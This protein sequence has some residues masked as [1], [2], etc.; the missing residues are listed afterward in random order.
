MLPTS[1]IET[2][3]SRVAIVAS[4]AVFVGLLLALPAFYQSF[5][6]AKYLGI[7]YQVLAGHGPLTLFGAI[8]LPHSPFWSTLIAAPSVWFGI[9]A[10]SWSHLLNGLSGVGFVLVI[11]A[12]GWQLRPAIGGLAAVGC[13][14]VPYLHDLARTGRLDVPAATLALLY[15]WIGLRAVR[16]G[17]IGL[18]IAAGAIFALGFL[19][20][21]IALPFAPIPSIIGLLEGR[22]LPR[23]ARV[24]A[25]ILLVA[26]AGVAWWFVVYA[27]Y[28]NEA[29]RLG[30]PAWTLIPLT[31]AAVGLGIVGS[32]AERIAG[33]SRVLA[34]VRADPAD[35]AQPPG[36][37]RAH[38]RELSGAIATLAWFLA[39]TFFFGRQPELKGNGLF[40]PTQ[41]RLYL[42]TWLPQ[43][44][45]VVMF[46]IVG[47]GLAIVAW[48]R[49]S[50]VYHAGLTMLMVSAVCSAPLVL[51]VMAVGEPPRNYLAQIGILLTLGAA[52]WFWFAQA[53]LQ[54]R[55]DRLTRFG[56]LAFGMGIGATAGLSLAVLTPLSVRPGVIGGIALGALAGALEIVRR[57][58][59][60]R[61]GNGQN[62]AIAASIVA[63]F[64]AGTSL[65]AE[66]ALAHPQS[67]SANARATSIITATSWI[68]ANEPA[69]TKV[70]FG[71]L[72]GYE[73]ALLLKADYPMAQ[74]VQNLV[75]SDPKSPDGLGVPGI[76]PIHDFIAV[77]I[78]PRRALEFQIF[79]ASS[80]QKQILTSG[81][82]I[83][84]YTIGTTTSVPSLVPALTPD[85]GFTLLQHWSWR[86]STKPD[87]IPLETYIFAVDPARVG[88]A[89]R[90]MYF[91]P[92]ALDRLLGLLERDPAAARVA[93]ADLVGRVQVSGT[94][95]Q[96]APLLARLK[97]LAGG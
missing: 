39:L 95:A 15:V 67:A 4:V 52:G 9:D 34:R 92:D 8:F 60:A 79:R 72:L 59:R 49:T 12:L 55:R 32:L 62:L 83:Y 57:P 68:R 71:S 18:A 10:A 2:T 85:H 13:L 94:D 96:D 5:D 6:E 63:T 3:S 76:G 78:S 7:G 88:F 46:G 1:R 40:Q 87:A 27:G 11:G 31:I 70:G 74:M 50:G 86:G 47:V 84:V 36:R 41:L 30:T 23:L 44:L 75:V 28:T 37:L 20:K 82:Q 56:P 48:F 80:F 19:V 66:H 93:A 73:M 77:D 29:Y 24:S 35:P 58:L 64:F 26:V 51:L 90:R 65:L 25:A 21:E 81:V 43:L 61:F 22:P 42:E 97:K 16:R 91:T 53:L 69:G 89:D 45:G 54:V 38:G 33:S 17:S 14:A